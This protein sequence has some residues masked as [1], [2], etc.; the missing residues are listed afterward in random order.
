L[1]SF[2][3]F[4]VATFV[5]ATTCNIGLVQFAFFVVYFLMVKSKLTPSRKRYVQVAQVLSPLSAS[6]PVRRILPCEARHPE[7]A[8]PDT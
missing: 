3:L 4:F 6:F 7:G 2:F 5:E 8:P 1:F